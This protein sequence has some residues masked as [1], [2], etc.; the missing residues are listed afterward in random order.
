MNCVVLLEDCMG[1]V[2]GETG[3]CRDTCL[4]GGV[5]GTREGSVQVKETVAVRSEISEAVKLPAINAEHEVRQQGVNEMF[6]SHAVR[7][8]VALKRKF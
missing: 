6:P 4:T 2:E 8:F 1:L 5:G 3:S 7:P